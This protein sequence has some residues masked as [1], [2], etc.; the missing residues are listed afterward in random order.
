M[1]QLS[2]ELKSLLIEA[3]SL[4]QLK[5]DFGR[6]PNGNVK[7]YALM[8]IEQ[9]FNAE[10]DD[11]TQLKGKSPVGYVTSD[12]RAGSSPEETLEIKS[13]TLMC[14]NQGDNVPDDDEIPF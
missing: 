12:G 5:A 14:L 6:L 3:Q 1:A 11:K 13:P 7:S 8:A 4:L 2:E 9:W 10:N